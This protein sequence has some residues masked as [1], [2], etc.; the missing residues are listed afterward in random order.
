MKRPMLWSRIRDRSRRLPM[1]TTV[2]IACLRQACTA[3]CLHGTQYGQPLTAAVN[4]VRI[5]AASNWWDQP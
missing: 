2:V 1:I 5:T 4:P 3:V